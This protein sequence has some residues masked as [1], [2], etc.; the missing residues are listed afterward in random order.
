MPKKMKTCPTCL[1]K[2]NSK[3]ICGV[4]NAMKTVGPKGK[5]TNA[6]CSACGSSGRKSKPCTTCSGKGEFLQED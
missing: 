3:D 6:R 5:I 2:K 1:G 4:C